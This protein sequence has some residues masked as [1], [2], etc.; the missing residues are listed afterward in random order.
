M[1]DAP[2]AM[3]LSAGFGTRL[4]GLSEERPKPMLPVCDAP[5]VRWAAS[6]CLRAGLRELAVNL[7]HK[8]EQLRAELGDGSRLGAG[9]R[10]HY[11]PEPEI[12]GT[13]GG[14]RAMARLRPRG[15]CVAVNAKIVTDLDLG[16]VL[17]A[18]RRS[19]ALA[20]MVLKP[21]PQAERWGAVGV[22]EAGNLTRLLALRRP[23]RGASRDCIFTGIQILEP[24]LVEAI[25]DGPC[26]II[27]TA[28]TALFERGAP[29]AGYVHE[30]YFHEH[31]TPARYLEGNLN[32]LRGLAAPASAPGPLRGIDAEARVEEG[33]RIEAPVRIAAGARIGA[34]ACVGPEVVV[35][36]GAQVAAGV[37][38]SRA[39]VWPGARVA[40]SV[41]S[42]IITP[43][44]VFPV[45]PAAPGDGR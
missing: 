38:L 40:A 11:S 27:R 35:G 13:G 23:G 12:L 21:D 31:S 33:A 10:V 26:C 24:E 14:V 15:T 18:H 34:G 8:G 16:P 32:L 4:R 22:D 1:Q 29:L 30:G 6:L 39:V 36:A 25:P 3:L 42:A 45:D 20:T 5:L 7:H 17:E 19:G 41:A 2:Y 28:Y 44:Q 43:R 9:V 37:E